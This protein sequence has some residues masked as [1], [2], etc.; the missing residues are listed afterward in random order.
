MS[1]LTG[2]ANCIKYTL[3]A[4]NLV[5]VITGIILIAVGV[6]VAGTFNEYD[7]FLQ[8][9]F[10]S[11]T[12]FLIVIGVFIFIIAFFGCC[13]AI[14]ENYWMILI[15]SVLLGIIFILELAAGISGYVLRNDAETLIGKQLEE[16]MAKYKED[17]TIGSLWDYTQREFSCCGTNSYKDWKL[18][19]IDLNN[20]TVSKVPMTCCDMPQQGGGRR[21]SFNGVDLCKEQT[22]RQTDSVLYIWILQ[23]YPFFKE[24]QQITQP[25]IRPQVLPKNDLQA[26]RVFL[27]ESIA[28]EVEI[29]HQIVD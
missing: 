3:F 21:P 15:F 14:K 10:Y 19:S 6:G 5:F 17:P 12:T 28:K 7:S 2:S 18:G 11:I 1:F 8:A 4:F 23:M 9:K 22:E 27:E 26:N 16:T 20:Y 25:L 24:C 29:K 13:G